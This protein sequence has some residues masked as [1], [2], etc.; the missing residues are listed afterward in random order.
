MVK[1]GSTTATTRLADRNLVLVVVVVLVL[2]VV[3]LVVL[4]RLVVFV[5]LV[6]SL[7]FNFMDH[8]KQ[9]YSSKTKC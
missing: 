5:V 6:V 3:M 8:F 4:V 9:K 7:Y 1:E 2:V